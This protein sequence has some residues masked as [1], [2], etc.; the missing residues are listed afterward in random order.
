MHTGSKI[1]MFGYM[2]CGLLKLQWNRLALYGHRYI[3]R[4]KGDGCATLTVK[5]GVGSIMLWGC[6][7]ARG[8]S[9]KKKTKKKEGLTVYFKV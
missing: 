4:K 1:V 5:Y 8:I 3:W 2:S 6:L 9:L 7:A